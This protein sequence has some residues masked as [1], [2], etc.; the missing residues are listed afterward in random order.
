[1][2]VCVGQS[3]VFASFV[4]LFWIW[5]EQCPE[6][7]QQVCS[8]YMQHM[9]SRYAAGMQQLCSRYM[10]QVCSRCSGMCS[11]CASGVHQVCNSMFVSLLLRLYTNEIVVVHPLSMLRNTVNLLRPSNFL[12]AIRN[13]CAVRPLT[14]FL[15]CCQSASLGCQSISL[16]DWA[17]PTQ[18]QKVQFP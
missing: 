4:V 10:Q 6:S 11:R 17:P 9:C 14:L 13:F 8:R 12:N 16:E 2:C 18:S 1:M 5:P 15:K 7:M 3:V